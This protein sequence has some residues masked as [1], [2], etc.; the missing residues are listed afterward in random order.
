MNSSIR[1]ASWLVLTAFV[2]AMGLVVL[3][4]AGRAQATGY[5]IV[6]SG[7]TAC[8][9][10]NGTAGDC[11]AEGDPLF[12]QDAQYTGNTPGYTDNGD[13]TVT[14]NVTGLMWQQSP[15]TNHDGM[16]NAADKKT[17]TEAVAGAGSLT[18]AGYSD[19]RLPTIKELYSLILFDGTDPSGVRDGAGVSLVPF[20]DTA[21]FDFAYGDTSAGERIID[22]Q[23]AS[24]TLYTATTMDGQATMFGVNFADGRIKGDGLNPRGGEK[25]FFVL[26]VRGN[27]GY[28]TNAFV[29]NGDGTVSDQATGLTWQQADSGQGTDWGQALAYCQNSTVARQAADRS[30]SPSAGSL[31]FS[32]GME[33]SSPSAWSPTWSLTPNAA[34]AG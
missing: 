18:L 11:A 3:P 28:G 13:G 31:S 8:Y 24:S 25:T 26:Y 29:D 32:K 20:I 27:P 5:P 33:Y 2:L 21:Y 9:D 19:W 4:Q 6:D 1:Y 10:T 12:G 23:F 15:D 14:D 34:A 30:Q 17:Y 7:Q 22:A 16:L